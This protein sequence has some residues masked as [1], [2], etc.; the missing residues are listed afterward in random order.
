MCSATE[1]IAR[2]LLTLSDREASSPPGWGATVEHMKD[3]PEIDNEFA[4]AWW[5][6]N[7]G[8]KPHR[9]Q[10]KKKDGSIMY[11]L[12][13]IVAK[14]C[15][16]VIAKKTVKQRARGTSVFQSTHPKVKDNKDHFPIND[17]A[18]GRN[19]LARVMQ[20]D[21]APSWYDGTLGG[22]QSAVK[23]AVYKKFPGL[24]SRK[25][26]KE[27]KAARRMPTAADGGQDRT[28]PFPQDVLDG[29][30]RQ[31][32]AEI[33]S[34]YLYLAMSGWCESQNLTGAAALFFKQWHEELAHADG[35]FRFVN[36]RLGE[37][38][39]GQIEAPPGRFS[40][41]VDVFKQTLNHEREVTASIHGLRDVANQAGDHAA[42]VFLQKYVDEQVEEENEADRLLTMVERMS[43]RPADLEMLDRHLGELAQEES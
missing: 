18:H 14:A 28:T 6:K 27:T 9:K 31:I 12:D 2:I 26:E 19:A 10:R 42:E 41:I 32:T 33:Y 36:D 25:K 5:M 11:M 40:D 16:S 38:S 21:S 43:D 24:K 30:N 29:L 20:Y 17:L 13:E 22:L 7:Q 8:F 39:L 15:T 34:A 3:H 23:R 37:V 35:F 4:L 1:R